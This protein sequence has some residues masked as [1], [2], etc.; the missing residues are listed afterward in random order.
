MTQHL[1]RS[2]RLPQ[3]IALYITAVV[4]AGVLLLPGLS[5]TEAG[6]ASVLAWG[7]DCLLGIPLALTFATLASRYP[8]A[9][10]V[11]TFTTRAF[12]LES[13]AAVGWFYFLASATGQIIVPLTGASYVAAALGFGR[14]GTFLLAIAMLILATGANL[15]GLQVSGKL[16]L[17]L[18]AGVVLMLVAATLVALPRMRASNWIPFAPH[19]F[20]AIGQVSVLIFYAFFGWEAIAQLSAEFE[21][22]ERDLRRSTWWS[23]GLITILYLGVAVTTVGTATYGTSAINRVSVAHLLSDSLGGGAGTTAAAMAFVISLG[24]TNAYMAATSRLGYALAR[25]GAFPAWLKPLDHHGVPIPSVLLVSGYALVGFVLAYFCG[26]NADTLLFIPNSLGIA[27][28]IVGTAAGVRLLKGKSRWLAATSCLLCLV[29]FV[30]AGASVLLPAVVALM[31]VVYLRLHAGR[32]QNRE[33]PMRS[34]V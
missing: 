5:A 30:F 16:A 28:F 7:F 4:G 6:P 8:N 22:P 17:A 9:G 15:R 18:S 26:W 12:G 11:S 2:I 14:E 19:G 34:A 20:A 13:G 21:H 1:V 31:A 24:T 10:G 33:E 27:T 29:V 23:V 32:K 3:A 25:D